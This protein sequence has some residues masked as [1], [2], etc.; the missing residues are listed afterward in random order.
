[1]R[2]NPRRDIFRDEIDCVGYLERIG[3]QDQDLIRPWVIHAH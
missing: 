2:G 3:I 1:V